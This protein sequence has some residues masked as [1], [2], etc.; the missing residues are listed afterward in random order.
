MTLSYSKSRLHPY[1]RTI[2]LSVSLFLLAAMIAHG[3]TPVK[4]GSPHAVIDQYCV[5]CHNDKLRSGGLSLATLEKTLD[6][7]IDQAAPQ[8][9]KVIV[10]LRAG[11][12]PPAGM[13]RPDAAEIRKFIA[14]L[15]T[16]IDHAAAAH[17]N[18][19][20]PSLHRLNRTE[21]ANSIRD[22]LGVDVDVAT[23]LPV[24]D[25]NHGFDNMSD[26]LSPALVEGYVRAAGKISREAVGDAAS[27]PVA[28]T[29]KLP[30]IFSQMRHVEGTPIGTRGGM[31]VTHNFPADGEYVFRMTFYYSG[32]GVFF[33]RLEKKQQI[34]VAVNGERVA[35]LD[36]NPAMKLNDDLVTPAIKVEAGPQVI[37]AAFINLAEGPVE[38]VL[39]PV[40]QSLVDVSNANIPGLTSLPHL[41]DLTIRGPFQATGISDTPSRRRIFTCR[42]IAGSDELPCARQIISRLARQAYRA[43]VTD[44]EMEE[45]LNF[46]QTGRN[47]GDFDS[48]VRTAVQGILANPRF[49]FRFERPP[50]GVTPGSNYRISDLELASRLSY[51][52]WSAGPDEELI[53]VASTNKLHL[54]GT[55]EQ[56]VRRMMADPKSQALSVNF[57]S[58]WLH[59]QNLKDVRPDD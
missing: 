32:L 42:P 49:V 22:L 8:W 26:A 33:G 7:H 45:L 43:P 47:D 11:M 13:P 34:E 20:R 29:Y 48:G 28:V 59:L 56:Q 21:Y 5:G 30:R 35:L 9:E 44:S 51:F 50:A 2:S 41:H 52:L 16:S 31:A 3:Q 57:A 10:K 12:M 23:L 4:P 46:Y 14:S 54:P 27:V 18:P 19:G 6:G 36:I 53:T 38:D 39:Q 15:E 55:L 58:Q 37:S 1:M 24:D 25:I 40:E 17:P